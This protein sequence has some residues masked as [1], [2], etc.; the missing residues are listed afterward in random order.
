[1]LT[2][3]WIRLPETLHSQYRRSLQWREIGSA[4]W[5]SI[6]ERQSRG[7]FFDADDLRHFGGAGLGSLL[8]QVPRAMVDRV[9]N[10]EFAYSPIA[11]RF[12]R[13]W[14]RA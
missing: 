14:S 11:I 1:M 8:R 5:Q 2:W 9:N 4:A 3:S 6:R 10:E 12:S 13:P 7:A